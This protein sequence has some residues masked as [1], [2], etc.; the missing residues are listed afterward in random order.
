MASVFPPVETSDEH[1]FLGLSEEINTELLLEAYTS[2]IFPWPSS[3]MDELV[4]WFSPP[5]RALLFLSEF[6]VSKSLA[7]VLKKNPYV[8]KFNTNFEAVIKNCK[9]T[10]RGTEEAGSWISDELLQAYVDFNNQ[11]Y[12]FSVEAYDN[13][14]LVGGLYG[15]TIGKMYA[16]ESMFHS[17]ADASKV[18]LSH[19][20]EK[21]KLEGVDWIDCQQ[22]TPLFKSFGARA[23]ERKKFL[24]LLSVSLSQK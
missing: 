5:N 19:L 13:E 3:S 1:G 4:P 2:G 18:C 11:G 7:K 16:G 22:M 14:K 17:E 9:E 20:V 15:V 21:L 23:V 10:P 24:E 12:C 8:I 6:H